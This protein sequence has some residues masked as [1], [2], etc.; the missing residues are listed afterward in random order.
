MITIATMMITM[1]SGTAVIMWM[2]ELVTDRGIG[3][4]MSVMV[5]TSVIAVIPGE[6]EQIYL[7][8]GIF[9]TLNVAVVCRR[10]SSGS[11]SS[12][13]RRSGASWSSTPGG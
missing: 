1:V 4:G 12:S 3:N 6:I 2:G 7:T 11:W 10:S 5:F 9:L 13:S 8:R